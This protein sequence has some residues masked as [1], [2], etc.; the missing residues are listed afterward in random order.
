MLFV[1]YNKTRLQDIVDFV[2]LL[3]FVFFGTHVLACIW[4]YIGLLD[5]YKHQGLQES[6]V[7]KSDFDLDRIGDIY[8]AS[9][10]FVMQTITT[11]G[12]GDLKG[13]TSLEYI[14]SMVLE[15]VGLTFFSF[16]MG[17]IS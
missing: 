11:V 17:S 8:M 4:C 3:I 14:F 5:K 12:Y 13:N 1:T 7:Y 9:V 10:Y 16:M 15:F 2:T 6:W